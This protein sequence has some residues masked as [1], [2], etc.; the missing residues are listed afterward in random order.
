MSEGNVE[1]LLQQGKY[2]E[3]LEVAATKLRSARE[4]N[5]GAAIAL[6]LIDESR[7]ELALG[8]RDH[9]VQSVDEAI[10]R[11]RRSFGPKDTH[12][13]AALELGAEIAADANMPNVAEARFRA[14]LDILEETKVSGV[15]LLKTLFHHGVFRTTQED[16]AGAARAFLSV[17]QRTPADA[18]HDALSYCAM[19]HTAL[20][21]LAF[22]GG[23][24]AQSRALGD[25]ALELWLTMGVARR[26]EVADSM[27]LVGASALAEGDAEAAI[28]F[29][30]TANEIYERCT[31]DHKSAHA[32]CAFDFARALDAHGRK[33]E[34]RAAYLRALDM[35]RE[36]DP[37]RLEIEQ[38]LMDL[39]RH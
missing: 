29:L 24:P 3:A 16:I 30:E 5:D 31:G 26:A 11:A 27:A 8:D 20:G 38:R 33:P 1:A 6:A 2:G 18:A 34:A 21:R 22:Q 35:F 7:A 37:V 17:I 36:G 14:A 28:S 19:A 13:V 10:S 9:T 25:R 32:T 39:A 4:V 23:K 12:Y 15:L